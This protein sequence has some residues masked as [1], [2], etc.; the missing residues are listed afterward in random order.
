[1]L[2]HDLTR[3]TFVFTGNE[4]APGIG[5]YVDEPEEKVMVPGSCKRVEFNR[6]K[7]AKQE[8]LCSCV[9]GGKWVG[10]KKAKIQSTE[11]LL[12]E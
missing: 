1:V 8:C 3:L 5:T 11:V 2:V 9:V 6:Y 4:R 12:L 10:G 7:G